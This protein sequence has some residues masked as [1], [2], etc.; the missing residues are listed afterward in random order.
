[1]EDL[2]HRRD[3]IGGFLLVL[4]PYRRSARGRFRFRFYLVRR[5]GSAGVGEVTYKRSGTLSHSK[6]C[7][8]S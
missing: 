6:I 7:A 2:E 5:R 8:T 3:L 1:M 4:L